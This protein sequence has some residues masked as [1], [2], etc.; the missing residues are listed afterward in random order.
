MI[1]NY[2]QVVTTL[3]LGNNIPGLESGP[4]FFERQS[5]F[6]LLFYRGVNVFFL[7]G[8]RLVLY[9]TNE[10]LNYFCNKNLMQ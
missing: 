10:G 4:G 9:V 3:L 6:L 5:K 7:G 2:S 1:S 8:G